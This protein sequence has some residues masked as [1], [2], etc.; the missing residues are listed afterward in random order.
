MNQ[1]RVRRIT[2]RTRLLGWATLVVFGTAC[3]VTLAP[4]WAGGAD[5]AGARVGKGM[6]DHVLEKADTTAEVKAR[7][8]Q[9]KGVKARWVRLVVD[10]RAVEPKCGAYN[11]TELARLDRQVAALRAAGIKIVLTTCY[12]PKWASDQRFWD[13][14]PTGYK[15]GYQ[16]FYPIRSGALVNYR[17]LGAMLAKR[18]GGRVHALECWNEPNLWGYIYPQRTAGDRYFG[19]RTYLRML[20]A[21]SRGVRGT[22]MKIRVLAGATAP[23]GQNDRYRTSPQAFARFLKSK[24]AGHLFDGYSHHPYTPGGSVFHAP[25]RPPNNPNT[26]VTLYNLRTLLR[27]FPGKPFYLTEYGYNTK[28]SVYFGGFSVSEKS[29]AQYLT[30]AYKMASA[31]KQVKVLFWYL[32]T[33]AK[34]SSGPAE[35]GVYTGLR[36]L[37]GSK[38]PSWYAY[39]KV[40]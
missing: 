11:E 5:P 8:S 13:D 21:F 2:G 27:I 20:Q 23:V 17:R 39:R 6:I 19:A 32:L 10:W 24:K 14:P 33:D 35:N 30:K 15:S 9:L 38:K 34:P 36:R 3:W 40:K 37:N 28:R 22:K 26:T 7:V 18:Y 16:S 31:H 4:S 1:H 25:G 12:M 29:Q